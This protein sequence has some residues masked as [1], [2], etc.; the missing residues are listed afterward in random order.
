MYLFLFIV[1][2]Y[3]NHHFIDFIVST[4]TEITPQT[5]SEMIEDMHELRARF[6]DSSHLQPK[7][8]SVG[9]QSAQPLSQSNSIHFPSLGSS[10]AHAT[11]PMSLPSGLSLLSSSVPSLQN[12]TSPSNSVSASIN[13][14]S[15]TVNPAVSSQAASFDSSSNV[16]PSVPTQQQQMQQPPRPL[17][18]MYHH[19][20]GQRR[21]R[22]LSVLCRA[23]FP[24]AMTMLHSIHQMHH[25]D[26]LTHVRCVVFWG[27][28]ICF[29]FFLFRTSFV[30]HISFVSVFTCAL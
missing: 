25:A 13:I 9:F 17:R 3:S 20:A 23:V 24:E 5:L 10:P 12:F 22:D 16:E 30:C 26:R 11:P 1:A 15:A 19:T 21:Q 6:S 2:H 8:N 27:F 14:N 29:F 7:E 4:Q 28:Q 18:F